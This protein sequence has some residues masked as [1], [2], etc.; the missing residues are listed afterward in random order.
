[1]RFQMKVEIDLKTT[2]AFEAY[3]VEHWE[4]E[5]NYND[6][7]TV[8]KKTIFEA[9]YLEG[10]KECLKQLHEQGVIK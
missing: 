9:A 7:S 1:M 5:P 8:V 2:K 6:L 4:E 10:A 3:Y